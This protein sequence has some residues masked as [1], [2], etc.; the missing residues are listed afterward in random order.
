MVE[1]RYSYVT[2]YSIILFII[3][4]WSNYEIEQFR[5]SWKILGI[6]NESPFDLPNDRYLLISTHNST[7]NGNGLYVLNSDPKVNSVFSLVDAPDLVV[8]IS[9]EKLTVTC[10]YSPTIYIQ[11]LN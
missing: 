4:R 5:K 3:Q 6:P 2:I 11:K 7:K 8:S 10:S 9:E 1:L